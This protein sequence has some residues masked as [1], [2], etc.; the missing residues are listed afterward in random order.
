[1]AR[2]ILFS[3]GFQTPGPVRFF[4]PQSK[5]FERDLEGM[6]INEWAKKLSAQ[7]HDRFDYAVGDMGAKCALLEVSLEGGAKFGEEIEKDL[8]NSAAEN[9]KS[10]QKSNLESR[11]EW[12]IFP[13][14]SKALASGECRRYLQLAV[15]YISSGG[16]EDNVIAANSDAG[17]LK[18]LEDGLGTSIKGL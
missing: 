15:Q 8:G 10:A 9:T 4:V 6:S 12:L 3:G 7:R 14:A 16:I 17:L 1:M 13:L 11:G 5:S 2:L 18:S